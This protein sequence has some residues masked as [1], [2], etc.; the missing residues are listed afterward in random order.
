VRAEAIARSYADTLLTLAQRNG[1]LPTAEQFLVAAD[2]LAALMKGEPRIATFLA[3]PHITL[4]Q[5][6]EALRAALGGRVPELFLRFVLVVIDKRRHR[7]LGEIAEAYRERVDEMMGRVRVH[8]ALSHAP[9]P[10]LR[11]EIRASLAARLGREVVPVFTIDPDLLGG[12]V[13]RTGGRILDGSLQT[14]AADLRRR[15]MEARMP[16][17]AAV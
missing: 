3:T 12:I 6:K 8:I 13:V 11:D 15:M 7:V 9:D 2:D 10:A 16:A 14:R 4:D 5:K 1:G 17:P